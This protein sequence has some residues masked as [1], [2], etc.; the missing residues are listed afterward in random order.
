MFDARCRG[1]GKTPEEIDEY[2]DMSMGSGLTPTEF[3][4]EEEGT[5]NKETG[6]FWCTDCYTRAGMP[7]GKA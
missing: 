1:C 7:L 6:K 3:C 5:F 4:V 2:V